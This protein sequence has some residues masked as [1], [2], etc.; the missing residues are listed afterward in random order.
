MLAVSSVGIWCVVLAFVARICVPRSI[1]LRIVRSAA[2][3]ALAGGAPYETT[4]T[5][6]H[7]VVG[8][9]PLAFYVIEP[10]RRV[11]VD[12]AVWALAIAG[13]VGLVVA[14]ACAARRAVAWPWAKCWVLASMAGSVACLALEPVRTTLL[15]GQV[16]LVVLG[17]VVVDLLWVPDR[18][19]GIALGIVAATFVTPLVFIV[20]LVL[21]A[22]RMAAVRALVTFGA[23]TGL[24]WLVRPGESSAYWRHVIVHPGRLGHVGSALNQSWWGLLGRLPEADAVLRTPLWLALCAVTLVLGVIAIHRSLRGGLVVDA[25]LTTAVVGLLVS[26]V[27]WTHHWSWVVLLFVALCATRARAVV[28][29]A[30]M[31]LLLVVA[32]AAP[33]GWHL[34]GPGTVVVDFS[35]LFA[36][37]LLLVTMAA[38]RT[39]VHEVPVPTSTTST[40]VPG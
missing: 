35:L 1:D 18:A 38:A 27:S 11:R 6:A 25:V 26:P 15:D 2:R 20:Y 34:T 32:V 36:G 22:Q 17:V 37:A 30:V 24:L 4:Y 19:R 23:L 39:R 21:A 40:S 14:L 31:W 5:A 28:V 7:L 12:V 33:Y 9:P 16:D 29:T 3:V 13:T 8:V 10:L